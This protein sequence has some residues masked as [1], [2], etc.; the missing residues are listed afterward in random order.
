MGLHTGN[1]VNMTSF[2]IDTG[3]VF[4]IKEDKKIL[5][6]KADFRNVESTQL[7]N[8]VDKNGNTISTVEHILSTCYGL[9]IDNLFIDLNSIKPVCDG[10]SLDFKNLN[11]LA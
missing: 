4:G 9:E 2:L 8:F 6:I 10:S 5:L 11:K 3:Y 1:Q 7:F